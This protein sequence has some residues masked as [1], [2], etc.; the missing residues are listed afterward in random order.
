[1]IAVRISFP[2]QPQFALSV[3]SSLGILGGFAVQ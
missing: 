3:F 2:T 1:M